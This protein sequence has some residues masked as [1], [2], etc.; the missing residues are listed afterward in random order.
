MHD[1]GIDVSPVTVRKVLVKKELSAGCPRKKAKL[2]PVMARKRLEGDARQQSSVLASALIKDIISVI[3]ADVPQKT[4]LKSIR[5]TRKR[6]STF[7]KNGE[8]RRRDGAGTLPVTHRTISFE[9][10]SGGGSG[11]YRAGSLSVIF[12]RTWLP[13]RAGCRNT[14]PLSQWNFVLEKGGQCLRCQSLSPTLQ[15]NF[16]LSTPTSKRGSR[17]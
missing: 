13:S 2:T 14:A 11:N 16:D 1:Y 7:T 17:H 10:G 4:Q 5:T 8:D 12:S 3:R 9:N 15:R 6:T